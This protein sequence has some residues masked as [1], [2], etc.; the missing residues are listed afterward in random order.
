MSALSQVRRAALLLGR[1]VL[2]FL[3]GV[4]LV[5]G[6]ATCVFGWGYDAQAQRVEERLKRIAHDGFDAPVW[7]HHTLAATAG[8]TGY[9]G[10]RLVG[11]D[12]VPAA[13]VVTT[14]QLGLHVRG[15]IMGQYGPSADWWADSIVRAGPSWVLV[16]CE[17]RRRRDCA[18]AVG[19]FL[20]SYRV[21]IE[22]TSP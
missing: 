6:V 5:E 10:A 4:A 9:G 1:L 3:I 11:L 8:T 15:W 16:V 12:P 21:A 7:V 22:Y 18:L 13:A 2:W 14:V 19:A 17:K 20:A